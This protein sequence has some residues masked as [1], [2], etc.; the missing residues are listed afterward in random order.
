MT[1]GKFF[2]VTYQGY[3]IFINVDHVIRVAKLANGK[4]SIVLDDKTT[5]ITD[6]TYIKV[7]G[8]IENITC[9]STQEEI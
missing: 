7:I 5:I 8:A 3:T 9:F 6:E 2:K 1:L 4:A